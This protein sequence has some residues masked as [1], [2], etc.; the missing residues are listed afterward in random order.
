[1]TFTREQIDAIQVGK[2]QIA[3][4]IDGRFGEY[5]EVISVHAKQDD[6]HGKLFVCGYC[7]HGDN[8]AISF[9]IKEGDALDARIYRISHVEEEAR[10]IHAQED[11][12]FERNYTK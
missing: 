12:N 4:G 7:E 8:G 1:M 9:S 5:R 10:F 3:W 11:W 2:T 6:I